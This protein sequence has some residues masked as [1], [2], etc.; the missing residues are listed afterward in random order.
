MLFDETFVAKAREEGIHIASV[1]QYAIDQGSHLDN[2]VPGYRHL[3]EG[4]IVEGVD[5]LS[6]FIAS[7]ESKTHRLNRWLETQY[8]FVCRLW[9]LFR[10]R[11]TKRMPVW[12]KHDGGSL[13]ILHVSLSCAA[14][15]GMLHS[16]GQVFHFEIDVRHLLL[17]AFFPWPNRGHIFLHSLKRQDDALRGVNASPAIA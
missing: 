2:L 10:N 16:I 12:I 7:Y 5:K 14:F 13:K 3:E 17:R 9:F 4:M 11:Q 6:G 8:V 1:E 15:D